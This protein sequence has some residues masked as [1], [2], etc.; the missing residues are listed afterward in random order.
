MA[1]ARSSA[2]AGDQPVRLTLVNRTVGGSEFE[3]SGG[4]AAEALPKGAV[5]DWP[6]DGLVIFGDGSTSA[7]TGAIRTGKAISQFTVE[8]GTAR[9]SFTP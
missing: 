8:P 9:I 7:A 3:L 4:L 2:V 6:R 1:R 5:V